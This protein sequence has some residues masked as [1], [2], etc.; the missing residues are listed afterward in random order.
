MSRRRFYSHGAKSTKALAEDAPTQHRR[1]DAG[2]YIPRDGPPA[3]ITAALQSIEDSTGSAIA[4]TAASAATLKDL[5]DISADV[6]ARY[7]NMVSYVVTNL[8]WSS[9]NSRNDMAD[10]KP[11]QSTRGLGQ[12]MREDIPPV[13]THVIQN[14][15]ASGC[16]N[17]L[18]G[19][20][21]QSARAD[22]APAIGRGTT[23]L[24]KLN[25]PATQNS[26]WPTYGLDWEVAV[27]GIYGDVDHGYHYHDSTEKSANRGGL[28]YHKVNHDA[29]SG[30]MSRE[31][32][33]SGVDELI[34]TRLSRSIHITD[35]PSGHIYQVAWDQQVSVLCTVGFYLEHRVDN[36][37]IPQLFNAIALSLTRPGV[38]SV[39]L[40]S[41]AGRLRF[42]QEDL[43][44]EMRRLHEHYSRRF[45]NPEFVRSQ[46]NASDQLSLF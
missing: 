3:L 12:L 5:L 28:P 14:C 44:D 1:L 2:M 30:R 23:Q 24:F 36:S 39:D 10:L 45:E 16:V 38:E 46:A 31:L 25:V 4:H 15:R 18:A 8:Q 26:Y 32:S 20:L 29:K 40:C 7:A 6:S 34:R 13:F 43:H 9:V 42:V 35:L 37:P 33:S 17:L 41:R 27:W 22:E 11:G 21:V 19:R